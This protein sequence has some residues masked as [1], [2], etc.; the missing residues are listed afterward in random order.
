MAGKK[1]YVNESFDGKDIAAASCDIAQVD[2]RDLLESLD[3][4]SVDLVLTDPPYAISRKTGFKAQGPQSVERLRVSMEFGEWDESEIDLSALCGLSFRALRKGGTAII[5]YDLWK[6]SYLSSAMLDAGFKQIRLIVWQKTNPVPLNQR[7]NYL[8]N[9]REI[10]VLGVKGSNPTFNAQY[11]SGVYEY[12]I[13]RGG[14]GGRKHPTQKPDAL[15][16]E[17]VQV[18]SRPKDVVVDPFLGSGTTALASVRNCRNFVGGDINEYY[19][20]VAKQR[21]GDVKNAAA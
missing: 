14:K 11:H 20:A 8:T 1:I 12:P 19:V 21:I 13:P 3:E 6:L 5:W 4:G 10:A 7:V 9:S 18:H 16:G 17:L 2:Y 15:F